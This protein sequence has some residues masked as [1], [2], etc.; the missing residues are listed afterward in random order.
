MERVLFRVVNYDFGLCLLTYR[1]A[2][3]VE[4]AINATTAPTIHSENTCSART[5]TNTV[6]VAEFPASSVTVRSTVYSPSCEYACETFW[7]CAVVPSPK[8]QVHDFR[9][10]LSFDEVP[11]KVSVCPTVACRFAPASATGFMTSLTVMVVVSVAVFPCASAIFNVTVYVPGVVN[12]YVGC[13][14]LSV[15]VV[16]SVKVQV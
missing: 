1:I 9:P 10:T 11:S 2:A 15:F 14:P 7:P 6:L 12:R 3:I 4:V 8:S 13:W 16:W 5:F